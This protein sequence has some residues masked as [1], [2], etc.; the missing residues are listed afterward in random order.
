MAGAAG[1]LPVCPLS[2]AR[3]RLGRNGGDVGQSTV[4][5]GAVAYLV[6]VL[7]GGSRRPESDREFPAHRWHHHSYGSGV[8]VPARRGRDTRH[9]AP[10]VEWPIVAIHWR[11]GGPHGDRAGIRAWNC[12]ADARGARAV[13]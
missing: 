12:F 10:F 5:C 13:G 3:W 1:A 6:V 4:W 8:V 9:G 7:D 11:F 2:V